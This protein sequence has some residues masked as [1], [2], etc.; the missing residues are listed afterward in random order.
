MLKRGTIRAKAGNLNLPIGEADKSRLG[1]APGLAP[2]K[3]GPL[4]RRI[5]MHVQF[6]GELNDGLSVSS[7]HAQALR[8]AG[9]EVSFF[10]SNVEPEGDQPNPEVI[11]LVT[12]E[13]LSNT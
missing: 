3:R 10:N 13:Q 12:F 7:H 5:D 1:P 6:A 4:R 11:H 9:V 2:R 8:D